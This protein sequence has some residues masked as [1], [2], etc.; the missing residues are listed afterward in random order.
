MTIHTSIDAGLLAFATDRQREIVEAVNAQGGA[1]AAARLLGLDHSTV[2]KA[3]GTLRRNAAARGYAPEHGW[4]GQGHSVPE[5]YVAR[6]VSTLRDKEGAVRQQWTIASL[7]DQR[8]AEMVREGV[9]AFVAEQGALPVPELRASALD[10]DVIP[11]IM[12]GDAHFGMLAHEAETG[13]NFDLKIAERE[14]LHAFSKLLGELPPVKR[15][16][17]N[18]LGDF[19]HYESFAGETLA[20]HNR[21]DYDTRY[22]KM[23]KVYSRTF[24]ALIDMAL[25]R[26]ETVD[27]I[28]NQGNH[29]QSNDIWMAELVR[30]AYGDSGRVNVLNNDTPFIGYRMGSTLCMTH[31]GHKAKAEKLVGVMISDFREDFGETE[32]HYIDTGHIH[33]KTVV[34]EHPSIT[35]ASWN[36]LAAGDQWH[37]DSG[38]RAR[39]SIGYALRSRRYGEVGT[40]TMPIQEVWDAI[41]AGHA[42]AG[43]HY[44]PQ[45]R[46]AFTA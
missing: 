34:K 14:M 38:Y 17:L 35:F 5:P 18:D 36:T 16:V 11:W 40:R 28:I 46:R 20:S 6:R 10:A 27:L 26:A 30:V 9:R 4:A 45:R 8:Y 1:R 37:S 42:G 32:F 13:A 22:P 43:T 33:H 29:S 23:V 2:V 15:L 39:R 44:V 12:V 31:H 19:T 24:R 21:L 25:T 3:V 7:D 41:R